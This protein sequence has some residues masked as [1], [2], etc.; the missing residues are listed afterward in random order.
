[1]NTIKSPLVGMQ[2]FVKYES[3]NKHTGRRTL[4]RDWHPNVILNTGRLEMGARD[5]WLDSSQIGTAGTPEPTVGDSQLYSYFNGTTSVY[6]NITGAQGSA[7][8]YGFRRKT[9]RYNVGEAATNISEAGF[10]WD[11]I[12]GAYLVSRVLPLDSLGEP[13]T[14]T[15]LADEFLDVTYEL[16]YYPPLV[17]VL[18]QVTLMGV[19]YNTIT[20]AAEVTSGTLWGDCIG[21]Q[22]GARTDNSTSYW[23]AFG[24]DGDIGDITGNPTGT[25]ANLVSASEVTNLA[26]QNNYKRRMSVIASANSWNTGF[27]VRCV[28][29][30]TYGGS[31]QTRFGSDDGLDNPIPKTTDYQLKLVFEIG[32]NNYTI[33]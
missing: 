28:R 2:G 1:M 19:T 7:P 21:R 32:W 22:M 33:P 15:P 27:G 17:D 18:G 29:W 13:T 6:S 4:L 8:Y 25:G 24:E 14:V 3:V 5:N 12:A 9:F 23:R 31:Y 30:R 20:R 10:G 26:Y 11:F 16:R